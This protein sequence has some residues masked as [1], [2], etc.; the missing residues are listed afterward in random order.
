MPDN[1][2]QTVARL[3]CMRSDNDFVSVRVADLRALLAA[4]DEGG[5]IEIANFKGPVVSFDVRE[6]YYLASCDRC[7]W[8]GS[9]EQCSGGEEDVV[10][11][12]CYT[13]GAD[14]GSVAERLS[15]GHNV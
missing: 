11:P 10:C 6:P 3:R 15:S 7:G 14:C 13:S 9:T 1:L 12:R 5:L 4:L 2:A 8:V